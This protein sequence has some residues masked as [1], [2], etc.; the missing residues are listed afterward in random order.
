MRDAAPSRPDEAGAGAKADRRRERLDRAAIFVVPAL[1]GL[2]TALTLVGPGR[3]RPALGGRIYGELTVGATELALRVEA[4]AHYDERFYPV[5]ATPLTLEARVGER[6]L[7]QWS[8][9]SNDEGLAEAALSLPSALSGPVTLLLHGAEQELAVGGIAPRPSPQ[10][11]A[12]EGPLSGASEGALAIDVRVPRGQLVPG[13]GERIEVTVTVT[14]PVTATAATEVPTLRARADGAD[15]GDVELE[16]TR[17]CDE[18]AC[19]FGWQPAVTAA[20]PSVELELTATALGQRGSW[21]GPLPITL[22]GLWL[23]PSWSDRIARVRSAVPRARAWLSLWTASGR[24]WGACAELGPEPEGRASAAIP[25]P[26]LPAGPLV[27][28]LS[29]DPFEP[30]GAATEWPLRPELDRLV[31]ARPRKLVDG[32]PRVVAAEL[33]RRRLARWPAAGLVLAAGAFEVA[34]LFRRQRLARRKLASELGAA[35]REAAEGTGDAAQSEGLVNEVSRAWLGV[36][37]LGV[38]LAFVALAALTAWG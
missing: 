30:T 23:D 21:R 27:L 4:L 3:E 34:F 37:A 32:M 38:S 19:R 20:A 22:S 29:T 31:V 18:R 8:G 2:V 14:V 15:V 25:L 10:R 7:G 12:P 28:V 17:A 24:S 5:A 9:Y 1:A 33:T 16:P 35:A 6:T 11:L 26:S 13:F 36:L